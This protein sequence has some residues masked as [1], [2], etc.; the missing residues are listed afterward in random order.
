MKKNGSRP[1]T[2]AEM[3]NLSTLLYEL[4]SPPDCSIP[5]N[6]KPFANRP[7]SKSRNRI[8]YMTEPHIRIPWQTISE[9]LR[10]ISDDWLLKAYLPFLLQQFSAASAKFTPGC[11]NCTNTSGNQTFR[12][13]RAFTK[14]QCDGTVAFMNWGACV[15]CCFDGKVASCNLMMECKCSLRCQSSE[16]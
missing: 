4:N 1:L 6:F 11:S 5:E 15:C 9:V 2:S 7:D 8:E 3:Q 14:A 13:C 10:G 16:P 12:S